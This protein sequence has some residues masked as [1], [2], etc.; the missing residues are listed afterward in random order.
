[1]P[2]GKDRIARS[3]PRPEPMRVD[4]S[5]VE[6]YRKAFT[7]AFSTGTQEEQRQYARLF[8]KKIEVDP[9]TGD[10]VIRLFRRPPVLSQKRTPA[11][12]ETGVRIGLVAGARFVQC[13][14]PP[15]IRTKL[16]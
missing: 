15:R 2:V 4:L 12:R 6:E 8:V 7:E 10:V 1:M 3:R 16:T 14:A 13:F 9:D 11:S 5:L